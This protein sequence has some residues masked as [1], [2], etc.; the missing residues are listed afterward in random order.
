MFFS[1]LAADD[2]LLI[3]SGLLF[4]LQQEFAVK[5]SPEVIFDAFSYQML[6][7]EGW[8]GIVKC[9]IYLNHKYTRVLGMDICFVVLC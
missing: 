8:I 2:A 6:L 7:H 5:S 9:F 4:H 1:N 3:E